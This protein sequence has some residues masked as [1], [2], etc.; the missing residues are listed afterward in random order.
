M[1]AERSAVRLAMWSGPRNI[2][3]ALMRAFENRPDTCVVDEPF[4]GY[5][6]ARTAIGHPGRQEI[7]DAMDCDWRSVARALTGPVP[8][9]RRLYY[10]KHMTHHMLG[11][12]DLAFTDALTNCFLVRE[13]ARMI[14]SYAR[15]RPDLSLEDLGLP[16]QWRI[17]EH[18][19]SRT[20]RQ[21]LV[22]DS[23]QVLGDPRSMLTHLCGHA[24][25]AFDE[26]MLR[27]PP[28]PRP[29]DGVWAPYWYAEV[30]KS[31]GFQAPPDEIV[32]VPS[33]YARVHAEAQRLYERILAG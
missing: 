12:V 22:L 26:A 18:V 23:R 3:T 9:G 14:V 29:S 24:G 5:Y 15:V 13:P 17:F 25:V 1:S 4:Y 11:E 33:R 6:L 2:S 8:D 21:P 16:Q 10:Q 7:V 32:T 30:E 19:R 27:W 31:T 28:G 20:G